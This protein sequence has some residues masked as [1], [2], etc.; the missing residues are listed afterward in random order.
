MTGCRQCRMFRDG[1]QRIRHLFCRRFLRWSRTATFAPESWSHNRSQECVRKGC[2]G[3]CIGAIL[4]NNVSQFVMGQVGVRRQSRIFVCNSTNPSFKFLLD[5]TRNG[6]FGRPHRL[7]FYIIRH[8]CLRTTGD[9]NT[10]IRLPVVLFVG[11]F[12]IRRGETMIIVILRITH[13]PLFPLRN[14]WTTCSYAVAKMPL[15]PRT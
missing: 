4:G 13:P 15:A 14:P 5:H 9:P 11:G 3:H 12:V 1:T 7:V 2:Q 8:Q 6:H 10:R